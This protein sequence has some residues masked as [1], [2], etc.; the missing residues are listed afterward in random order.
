MRPIRFSL[1]QKTLYSF[2]RIFHFQIVHHFL[3]AQ[4]IRY[5]YIKSHLFIQERFTDMHDR[6]ALCIDCICN[7]TNFLV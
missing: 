2:L 1:F 5:R 7:S 4:S 3:G 6:T